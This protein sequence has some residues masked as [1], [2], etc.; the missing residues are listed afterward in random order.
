MNYR[1]VL[2][3]VTCML[4]GRRFEG[5]AMRLRCRWHRCPRDVDLCTTAAAWVRD[6]QMFRSEQVTEPDRKGSSRADGGW[7]CIDCDWTGGVSGAI[8]HERP[9][10]HRARPI[11]KGSADD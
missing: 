11:R 3:A 10:A 8:R 9:G 5:F 7:E 2:N 1:L 4:C 6:S